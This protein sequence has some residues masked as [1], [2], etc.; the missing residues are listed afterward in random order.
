MKK[1]S[2]YLRHFRLALIIF[3]HQHFARWTNKI[4]SYGESLQRNE[5]SKFAAVYS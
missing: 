2:L 4:A 5:W 3:I 1:I